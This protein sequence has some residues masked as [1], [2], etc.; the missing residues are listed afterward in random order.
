M[1]SKERGATSSPAAEPGEKSGNKTSLPPHPPGAAKGVPESAESESKDCRET[2]GRGK[3]KGV[4]QSDLPKDIINLKAPSALNVCWGNNSAMEQKTNESSNTTSPQKHMKNRS[5]S[6][7][8]M[9]QSKKAFSSQK[10]LPGRPELDNV[11]ECPDGS[12]TPSSSTE[13]SEK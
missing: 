13:E 2:E 1:E 6:T 9:Q 11:K 3:T 5:K 10:S 12:D 8:E 4:L 7:E